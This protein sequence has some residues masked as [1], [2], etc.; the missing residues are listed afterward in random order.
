MRQVFTVAVLRG[1]NLTP[2]WFEKK[3]RKNSILVQSLWNFVYSSKNDEILIARTKVCVYVIWL[4][5]YKTLNWTSPINTSG[6][7]ID[8]DFSIVVTHARQQQLPVHTSRVRVQ[9]WPW[10]PGI[11]G[12]NRAST[13][14]LDTP[15]SI[16]LR[17]LQP[18]TF[19]WGQFD[20]QPK[21]GPYKLVIRTVGL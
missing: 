6:G 10:L 17:F 16:L 12:E 18:F 11:M 15:V 2:N 4:M 1:V 3:N 14:N 21:Y 20:P 7:Q 8:T 9:T 13:L 19:E 5:N